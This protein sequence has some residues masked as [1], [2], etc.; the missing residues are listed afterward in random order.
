MRAVLLPGYLI[1]CTHFV[2]QERE[3]CATARLLPAQLLALKSGLLRA[4]A[5]SGGHLAR[6]AAA[7]LFRHEA[8]HVLRVYDL[9]VAAGWLHAAPTAVEGQ[10]LGH[11]LGFGD[12]S[13]EAA[14]VANGG[15]ALMH[16]E[17]AVAEAVP[18][19]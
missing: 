11:D 17:S 3:L 14:P 15:P 1:G 6:E 13:T 9:L 4:G 12:T 16:A 7:S 8:T 2:A 18:A 5:A 19:P 10:G